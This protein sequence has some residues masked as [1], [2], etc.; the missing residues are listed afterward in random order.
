[1]FD[2]VGWQSKTEEKEY[3]ALTAVGWGPHV[4]ERW[5]RGR[6]RMSVA[7]WAISAKRPSG[8]VVRFSVLFFFNFEF[9]FFP[10]LN[11]RVYI[12]CIYSKK[13]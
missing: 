10:F 8:H 7:S 13:I 3:D 6:E 11:K 9:L 1:L 5:E 12:K 4:I 2:G